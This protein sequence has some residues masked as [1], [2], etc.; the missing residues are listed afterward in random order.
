MNGRDW[1]ALLDEMSRRYDL[2]LNGLRLLVQT[3]QTLDRLETLLAFD[4][5][6]V[7]ATWAEIGDALGISRQSAFARH[8]LAVRRA[9]GVRPRPS[10]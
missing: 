3:R 10:A 2:P 9:D 6:D 7:G 5:R 1:E 8:R 4:A